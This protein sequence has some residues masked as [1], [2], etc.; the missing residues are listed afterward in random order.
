MLKLKS[1]SDIKTLIKLRRLY[2]DSFPDFERLPFWVLLYKS[3][4]NDSNLYVICDDEKF[5]GLTNLAY[6]KD[7]VYLYYLAI[8]P[9]LQSQGYGSEILR[10][11]KDTYPNKRILLNIEKVEKPSENY[12]Q[13]LKRK[14]FYELNGFQNTDF[15]VKTDA[16]TYEILYS[17]AHVAKHE[18]D[19]LFKSY[20]NPV[21]RYLFL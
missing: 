2:I 12:A 15:E 9:S 10:Y 18:Y 8:D 20:L 7:I 1:V 14:E 11:L 16:I 21:L 4:K 6:Y 5:V 13:R 19:S 3:Q 17:G